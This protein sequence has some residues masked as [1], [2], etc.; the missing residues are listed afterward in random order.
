MLIKREYSG[1]ISVVTT[2]TNMASKQEAGNEGKIIM[3]TGAVS[4][5]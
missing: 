2:N 4:T 5:S 3:T 1:Y